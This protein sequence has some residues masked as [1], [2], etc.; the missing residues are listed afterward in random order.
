MKLAVVIL[1]AGRGTR[2]KSELPK[3]M[4]L[5]CGKPM[6]W[7]LLDKA[8]RL[9]AA[10]TVVVAGYGI[11]RVRT[12]FGGS[13]HIV[14]QKELLGSGH[15][16]MQAVKVLKGFTGQVAVLYCDTPLISFETLADLKKAHTAG[17]ADCTLLSM[18]AENP[19]GY[20]RVLK[21]EGGSV[22]GI[23]EEIDADEEQKAIREVN[24]GAYF[25]GAKE[26]F[27]ALREIPRNPVKNEYYLTDVVEILAR[28]GR[29]ESVLVKDAR[30]TA[31]VNTRLELSQLQESMQTKILNELIENGVNIR[32]PKTTVIDAGVKIGKDTVILPHTVIEENT[33]IGKNC[34]I[35]PF[36][37]LRGAS[38]VGDGSVIG[39]F[40]ELVRSQ[41]GKNS[42]VKHLSY[43]GDARIGNN[44]NVGAGTIT[45]NF[46]GKKKHAT[47]IKDNAQIGSGTVLIAPVTVGRG[48]KTGAGA[49]VTK[50]S[51]IPDK[52]IVIGVPAKSLSKNS[53]G[54][55]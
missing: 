22:R 11:E 27:G 14:E 41:V 18:M 5:I 17:E 53:K 54:R 16:V 21:D 40:V 50:G 28:H 9:K 19:R 10:T 26:L 52:G 4:H 20:G 44:V 35:G 13:A 1:A 31:G 25:F 15:A 32:D 7:H 51:H 24:V 12:A 42:Q 33:V 55:K 2:M 46:D 36:A 38:V 29:V 39:N 45:A 43:L 23:I 34:Q 8:R 49:V 6:L 37:R 3:A 48:A 47:V 30:E